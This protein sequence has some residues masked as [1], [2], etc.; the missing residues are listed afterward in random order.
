MASG[1]DDQEEG[2][3]ANLSFLEGRAARMSDSHSLS[4]SSC[5]ESKGTRVLNT[6]KSSRGVANSRI[7]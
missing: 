3:K 4:K 7:E 1:G 2:T 5:V 6:E